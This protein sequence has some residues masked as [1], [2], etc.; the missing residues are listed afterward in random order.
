MLMSRAIDGFL[1]FRSASTA[2]TT[3]K[4]DEVVLSQF[5]D[6]LGD[7]PVGDLTTES[8]AQYLDFQKNERGLSA[9]TVRRHLSAISALY[10]WLS[11]PDI[12]LVES[13]P[14]HQVDA[15]NLPQRKIKQIER[16]DIEKLLS[17]TDRAR[18]KRRARALVLFLLDTGARATEVAGVELDDVNLESG[19]VRVVGKGDKER[20]VYLGRRALSALWLYVETERPEPGQF[21][22]R[23]LFLS[24]DGYPLD[25]HSIRHVLYR[26]RDWAELDNVC[27]HLFRHQSAI[28][29]LRGGM[30]VFTLK[31]H[32]GHESLETTRQYLTALNDEDV[33]RQAKRTSPSDNWKL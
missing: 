32:L 26:L 20:Y 33:E 25:R 30:D 8:I 10:N 4:T 28:E 16:S 29:R 15:P 27:P 17:V 6:W 1:K 24:Q 21:G 14:A 11:S 12:G 22:D 3:V 23:T 18:L 5:L 9:H 19:R 31:E 7:T 2:A 13:N